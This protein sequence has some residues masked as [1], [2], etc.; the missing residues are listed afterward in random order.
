MNVLVT[1]GGGFIGSTLVD[2]L[3][4]AGHRVRVLDNFSTGS[5]SNLSHQRGR[6]ELVEGDAT[7]SPTVLRSCEAIETIFHLAAIPNVQRSVEQPHLVQHNGEVAT[8]CLLNAAARCGVKRFILASSCSVYG[9]ADSLPVAENAQLRPLSPYAA[10]KVACEGYLSA[11]SECF[12][13]DTVALRYFN[14]FGP[15]QDPGNPYSGVLSIFAAGMMARQRPRVFGDGEQTRDFVN[16]KDV[17]NANLLTM[18]SEKRFAGCS[19][20]IGSGRPS[21]LNQVIGVLNR[22]LGTEIEPIYSDPRTGDIRHSLADLAL[23]RELLGYVP[24]VEL[25]T[26]LRE[27]LQDKPA[28]PAG[29]PRERS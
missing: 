13:I 2:A 15:R 12:G 8:V 6:I 27:L 17:V 23:A 24:S 4:A 3:V 7:D 22:I 29:S 21:S 25:E 14:V 19:I 18:R 16:V 10:S 5:H 9:R 11:F 1:G 20:N 28:S 26:G